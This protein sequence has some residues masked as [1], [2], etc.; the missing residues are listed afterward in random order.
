MAG[1]GA[2]LADLDLAQCQEVA[3]AVLNA[4]GATAARQI[5]AEMILG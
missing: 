4:S 3:E 5:A 2:Q 1:V